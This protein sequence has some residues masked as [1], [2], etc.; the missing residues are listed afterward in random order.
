MPKIRRIQS[1][2]QNPRKVKGLA[3]IL[4]ALLLSLVMFSMISSYVNSVKAEVGN[5]VT[6][7]QARDNI[8]AYTELNESLL[9]SVSVPKRWTSESSLVSLN[10]LSGRRIPFEV[11]SGT[12]ITRD[13]LV[14]ISDINANERE[15]AINVDAVTGIAGRVKPGDRVDVYAVFGEV[16]G[17]T[18]QVQVIATDIRIVT[19]QGQKTI[20][21]EKSG[22]ATEQSVIPVTIA[23]DPN[24]ALS[25]TYA[26]NFAEEVRLVGLP[27]DGVVD[28][29]DDK[30]VF[31]AQDL[32]GTKVEEGKK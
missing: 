13:M 7:Y 15:I 9:R 22:S 6:V 4:V 27:S 2:N 32:G 19:V 18:K 3:F 17:L 1:E 31:D 16:P 28:R 26:A 10:A 24:I 11:E 20:Q 14:P 30:T 12:T 5:L 29:K 8:P 23:V 21:T 25:I